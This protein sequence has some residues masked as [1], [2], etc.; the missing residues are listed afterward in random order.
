MKKIIK[1]VVLVFVILIIVKEIF[2]RLNWDKLYFYSTNPLIYQYDS[3]V[4]YIY[5]PNVTFSK[6]GKLFRTNKQCFIGNDFTTTKKKGIFRIAFVGDCSIAGALS[7]PDYSN[8]CTTIQDLFKKNH[9]SVEIY[10]FGVDGDRRRYDEFKSIKYQVVKYMPDLIICQLKLPLKTNN[11]VREIYRSYIIEYSKKDSAKKEESELMIDNIHKYKAILSIIDNI[12]ILKAVCIKYINYIKA[13]EDD[14]TI[15]KDCDYKNP[16]KEYLA[17]ILELYIRKKNHPANGVHY[18]LNNENYSIYSLKKSLGLIKNL[19]EE[20]KLK[21][22]DLY[23][24]AYNYQVLLFKI[25]NAN[26]IPV[27]ALNNPFDET[28]FY[29]K[30][31]LNKKGNK[32]L[33]EE[34]YNAMIKNNLV[35]R[36]YLNK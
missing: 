35:P 10:N 23:F 33:G 34:F 21:N 19:I 16:K 4:G 3:I 31:H 30:E 15:K 14:F 18:V 17:T 12:Y 6:S 11:E 9:W 5:K 29:D 22:I 28:M 2:L 32:V 26:N 20:L 25:A 1:I 13:K 36:M 24:F 27:I 7:Y 8:C